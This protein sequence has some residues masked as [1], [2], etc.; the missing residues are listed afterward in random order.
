MA[1][2]DPAKK[3]IKQSKFR[4]QSCKKYRNLKTVRWTCG[5][6]E[7]DKVFSHCESIHKLFMSLL[8]AVKFVIE[9]FAYSLGKK[10]FLRCSTCKVSFEP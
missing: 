8:G 3:N 6:R 7:H 4:I 10:E 5:K 1:L 9:N 2:T